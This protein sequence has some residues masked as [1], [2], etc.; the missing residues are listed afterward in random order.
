MQS[1]TN[2]NNEDVRGGGDSDSV[3]PFVELAG[4][5]EDG[6]INLCGDLLSPERDATTASPVNHPVNHQ[7]MLTDPAARELTMAPGP[8]G[9]APVPARTFNQVMP[10]TSTAAQAGAATLSVEQIV[11]MKALIPFFMNEICDQLKQPPEPT[12]PRQQPVQGSV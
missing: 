11:A 5:S 3:A 4:L 1:S 10:A 12:Q 6:G 9:S 7:I 2:N 8:A